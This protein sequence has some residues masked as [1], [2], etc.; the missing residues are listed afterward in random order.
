MFS[1]ARSRL[2]RRC[3][4]A[5]RLGGVPEHFNGPFHW[6]LARGGAYER[7]GFEASWTM[8]PTGTGAMVAALQ[9]K[10]VDV[11]CILLEGAVAAIGK[12]APL[13][14]CGTWVSTPLTWGVH[15]RADATAQSIDDLRGKVFGVSRM[16]SGSH[17]MSLVM[18]NDRAWTKDEVPLHVAGALD[19][20]RS[21]MK[22]G[23]IDAWLWEKFTTNFLVEQGEW[24][25]I[26]EVPTPWP[27]FVLVAH[28]DF[29]AERQADVKRLLDLTKPICEEYKANVGGKTT[30]Y[31]AEN[32]RL[33]EAQA[34]E[35][36]ST[37]EWA[38]SVGVP[39]DALAK[40]ATALQNTGQ[41]NEVQASTVHQ[42][43]L[44]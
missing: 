44:A 21:A 29:L 31:V 22:A 10:E 16:G 5:L 42:S 4:S 18:A 32:H 12:G 35:W 17:L 24:R 43:V 11:A 34:A 23:S 37:T 6:S 20:A 14:I 13:R 2:G 9:E 27:C 40:A 19:G 7:A 41:L 30:Q 39:A 36:L 8:Y 15:V 25:R 28:E 33:S 26:G 1:A 38:C 3:F